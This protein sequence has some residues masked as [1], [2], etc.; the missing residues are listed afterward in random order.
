[1]INSFK[2]A[3]KGHSLL[4]GIFLIQ[5]LNLG[6]PHCKLIPYQGS[7]QEHPNGTNTRTIL[8]AMH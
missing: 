8:K 4:Q 3:T 6:L 7:H 1:M 5:G 2:L